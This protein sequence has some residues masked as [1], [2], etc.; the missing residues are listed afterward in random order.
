MVIENSQSSSEYFIQIVLRANN[1]NFFVRNEAPLIS[2]LKEI[3]SFNIPV[4]Y[5]LL[6]TYIFENDLENADEL[7]ALFDFSEEKFKEIIDKS[8]S[9]ETYDVD[10]KNLMYFFVSTRRHVN[11]AVIQQK[12]IMESSKEALEI[13]REAETKIEEAELNLKI[14]EAKINNANK[15][16]KEMEKIKGSIYTEFIAILGIFSA[17]IFG[18]FGSFDGLSKAIIDISSKWSMGKVLIISSGIMLS[19]TLLIFALLQWVARITGRK[20]NSCDCYKNGN[21]CNHSLFKRHRTLFSAI[22]SFIFVFILGE[23]IESYEVLYGIH[24]FSLNN[25]LL[26]SLLAWGIPILLLVLVITV[27]YLILKTPKNDK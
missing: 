4:P 25:K 13:S 21:E 18:L 26:F 16:I 5:D 3:N 1:E 19:L 6:T 20:L 9:N 2:L 23:Y 8:N 17:L 12:H 14:L 10:Y 27:L 24:A 22:F 11:L 15:T 7:I